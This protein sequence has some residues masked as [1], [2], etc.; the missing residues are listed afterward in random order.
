MDDVDLV[1]IEDIDDL[2]ARAKG[3]VLR[4]R[5]LLRGGA[6]SRKSITWHNG[7]DGGRWF[8]TNHIDDTKQQLTD[9]QLWTESNIGRWLDGGAVFAEA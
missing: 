8:I 1:R 6:F 4:I 3:H 7:T 9:E 2:R 5:L